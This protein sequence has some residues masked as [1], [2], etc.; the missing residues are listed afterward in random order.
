MSIAGDNNQ[1]HLL[2]EKLKHNKFKIEQ[3]PMYRQKRN[4]RTSNIT[5]N[6]ASRSFPL[7]NVAAL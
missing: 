4:G 5:V 3:K 1:Q 2:L 7:T 6:P